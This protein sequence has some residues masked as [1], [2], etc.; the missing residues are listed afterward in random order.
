MSDR[1]REEILGEVTLQKLERMWEAHRRK[2]KQKEEQKAKSHEDGTK[3]QNA[4]L[5]AKI[6]NL[7]SEN[8]SLQE[9]LNRAY[10]RVSESET[11]M[12]CSLSE[13]GANEDPVLDRSFHLTRMLG[14]LRRP[15]LPRGSPL[16]FHP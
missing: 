9:E 11:G 1:S 15:G 13:R 7:K 5:K 16:A 14:A 10:A 6:K 12:L 3:G 4:K 2:D 8:A